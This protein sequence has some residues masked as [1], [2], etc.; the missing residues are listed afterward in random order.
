VAK[1]VMIAAT[2]RAVHAVAHLSWSFNS[3][4]GRAGPPRRLLPA[5]NYRAASAGG[6]TPLMSQPAVARMIHASA[7]PQATPAR[8][9]RPARHNSPITA[10]EVVWYIVVT[11]RTASV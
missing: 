8:I 9:Q 4:F 6:I 7:T 1:D 11:F 10:A 3:Q 2:V 5:G